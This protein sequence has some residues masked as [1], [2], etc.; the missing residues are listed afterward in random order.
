MAFLPYPTSPFS[1]LPGPHYRNWTQRLSRR[2][3]GFPQSIGSGIII[4][5]W[6]R[7]NVHN[8]LNPHHD[9]S[10]IS[11]YCALKSEA[12]FSSTLVLNHSQVSLLEGLHKRPETTTAVPVQS[13]NVSKPNSSTD[14]ATLSYGEM[15]LKGC[16]QQLC[17]LGCLCGRE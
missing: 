1:F 11:G 13:P 3:K 14:A 15:T 16:S 10:S 7:W 17:L 2:K 9:K 6:E 12:P 8:I 5:P 4:S